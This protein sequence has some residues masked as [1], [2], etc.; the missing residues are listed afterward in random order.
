LAV[1]VLLGLIATVPPIQT[2]TRTVGLSGFDWALVIG[3]AVLGTL[4][5]EP[6]KYARAVRKGTNAAGT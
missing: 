2:V 3:A 5:R 6:V 1:F 4:W